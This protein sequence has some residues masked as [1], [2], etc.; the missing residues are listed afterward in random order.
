MFMKLTQRKKFVQD[1]FDFE[2]T[3]VLT[4]FLLIF[5]PKFIDVLTPMF[6]DLALSWF[7]SKPKKNL[8][9]VRSRNTVYLGFCCFSLPG[10]LLLLI[11][12]TDSFFPLGTLFHL[13]QLK[14]IFSHIWVGI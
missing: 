10:I 8:R 4:L 14:P 7:L 6:A 2:S 1:H 9:D 5:T 11:L 3:A 12:V 13:V